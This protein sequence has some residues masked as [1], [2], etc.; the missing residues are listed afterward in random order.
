MREILAALVR[1]VLPLIIA[2]LVGGVASRYLPSTAATLVS[3][4]ASTVAQPAAEAA[5][6]AINPDDPACKQASGG[7]PPFL[8]SGKPLPK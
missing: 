8:T 2:G 7:L 6:C 3:G 4:A 1:K 5:A